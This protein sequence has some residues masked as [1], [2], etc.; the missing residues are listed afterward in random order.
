MKLVIGNWKM[1]PN[2]LKEAKKTIATF[3]RKK[4]KDTGVTTVICPPFVFLENL[5][6]S[7][8]GEK[9]FFGAQNLFWK[10]EGAFT[11]EISSEMIKDVG[12]RFVIIGHSERRALGES[13][14]LIARKVKISLSGGLHTVLCVGEPT[15]DSQGNYLIFVRDQIRESLLGVNK[16]LIKK[17]IIAYEPIWT[18]GNGHKAMKP[19]EIHQM[20][21]FIKKQ[22]IRS[23]G[24]KVGESIS[25][26]YGGSVD[27][28]N[29][30]DIVNQGE[31]DGVLVGR[32]S[33]N[34]YEFAKMIEEVARK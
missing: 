27:S 15:R 4:I 31:V 20:V 10:E 12:A 11:G 26:L 33:L 32:N 25:I 17:L 18:V 3:K 7:Y 5:Y 19:H 22:L 34:P 16:N 23:Y 6:R 2:T 13:N 30:H 29:V 14:E 8:G 21:L 28:D 1:H 24:R 9:V